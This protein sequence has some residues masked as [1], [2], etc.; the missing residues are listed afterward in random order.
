MLGLLRET[1][2]AWAPNAVLALDRLLPDHAH[3][4]MKAASNALALSARCFDEPRVMRALVEIAEEELAHFKQ[5]LGLL[6]SR[7]IR[8]GVPEEDW[9]VA[10]LRR[11][12]SSSRAR[13]DSVAIVVTDRLIVGALIEARSCERFKLL[14]DALEPKDAGLASFYGDL[15][16]SE[17]RHYRVFLELATRMSAAAY[18]DE[19]HAAIATIEATVVAELRSEPTIHG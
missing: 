9:Y 17:A 14:R 3:C 18:V 12:S 4:E 11:R 15:L 16:A 19:R 7:G 6:D 5:V 8:L 2:A 10:E 1:A 13:H